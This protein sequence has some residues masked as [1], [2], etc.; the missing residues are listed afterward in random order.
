MTIFLP[1]AGRPGHLAQV[2]PKVDV[3]TM[4]QIAKL[5]ESALQNTQTQRLRQAAQRTIEQMPATTTIGELLSSEAGAMV[6]ALSL[7]EIA[8]AL[9]NK[10][11]SRRVTVEVDEDAH[12]DSA[13]GDLFV[14]ILQAVAEEPRTIGQLSKHLD[15]EVADL[16]GYLT[17]MK[18]VGKVVTTGRARGTRY[19]LA[20]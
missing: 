19:H 16:R 6:R 7:D 8:E 3:A 15:I 1:G 13:E 9:G 4:T 12:D 20:P 14:K 10:L 17:W 18:D 5:F 2:T 11:S